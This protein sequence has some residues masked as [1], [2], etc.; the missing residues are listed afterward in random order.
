[1]NP[2][3]DDINAFYDGT[4]DQPVRFGSD[5][6]EY[7]GILS[8]DAGGFNLVDAGEQRTRQATVRVRKCELSTAPANRVVVT[9]PDSGDTYRVSGVDRGSTALEWLIRLEGNY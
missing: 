9:F 8:L 4:L 2:A 1:M 5:V 7:R 3:F 6:T